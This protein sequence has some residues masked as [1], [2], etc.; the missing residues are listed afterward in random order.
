MNNI[1]TSTL[2]DDQVEWLFLDLNS[3]FASCQQ[4]DNPAFRGK[5][6][7]VVPADGVDTTCA[8]A[9]STEAKRLGIKTGTPVWEARQKCPDIIMVGGGHKRYVEYHNKVMTAIESCLHVDHIL[10]I[11][12]C[13]CKLLGDER[14]VDNAL[15]MA[16]KVKSAIRDQ[17]G[18][19]LTSS[20]GLA[21][22]RFLGKLASNMQKPNGLTVLTKADLPHK[23]MHLPPRALPG[24]GPR[25]EKRL[26]SHAIFTMADLYAADLHLLRTIYNGVEGE[27]MYQKLRGIEPWRA[28][29]IPRAISHEHVLEPALRNADGMHA[30]S[31]YLLAKAAERLRGKGLACQRLSF[32]MK[33]QKGPR[34]F[35]RESRDITF[36][37][38]DDTLVLLRILNEQIFAS[39]PQRRPFR[40]GVAVSDFVPAGQTQGDFFDVR[41]ANT[42]GPALDKLNG[43]YG[44][45]TIYFGGVENTPHGKSIMDFTSRIAFQRVPQLSEYDDRKKKK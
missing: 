21:P 18:E 27:R 39:L 36:H 38:T 9:A 12:E 35:G 37:P 24:I 31:H 6:L 34:E 11:D 3:F 8:I 23:I 30:F 1:G 4:Q 32:N 10:S 5:P 15:A 20:I 13:A 7:I 25:M 41:P 29:T 19:C 17:V 16:R 43:K 33:Y 2:P 45:G 22:N 28:P 42:L 44:R 40:I 26:D 14:I